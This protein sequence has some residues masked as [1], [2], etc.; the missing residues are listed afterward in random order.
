MIS[1]ILSRPRFSKEIKKLKRYFNQELV[2]TT[3]ACL[4]FACAFHCMATPLLIAVLP[5]IGLTFLIGERAEFVLII[6][7]TVLATGSLVWGVRHHRSWQVFLILVAAVAFIVIGR[8]VI[9]GSYAVVF[10]TAS[11]ILLAAAHL[12]N[13]HLCKTCPA[14]EPR[15]V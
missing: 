2:D 3:G 11:G 7:A 15:E 4:S 6:I 14:C 9:E 10:H 5:F 8:T 1:I 13:R 12:V